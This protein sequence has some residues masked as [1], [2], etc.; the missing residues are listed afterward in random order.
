[1]TIRMG[2]R[3]ANQKFFEAMKAVKAGTDIVLTERGKAIAVIRPLREGPDPDAV[4]ER[5]RAIGMLQAAIA[6]GPM[7][8]WKPGADSGR[9]DG[10]DCPKGP[11]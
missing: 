2:L 4:V 10:A 8:P 1:M 9:G 7:P 11:G 6:T 3:E 5:F